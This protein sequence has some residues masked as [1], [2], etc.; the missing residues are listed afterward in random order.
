MNIESVQTASAL[1]RSSPADAVQQASRQAKAVA[2]QVTS[3][4][5]VTQA[6]KN[7]PESEE[8]KY[9]VQEAVK[10][11]EAFVSLTSADI[12]FSIDEASGIQVVKILDRQS[13][14]V[15]RQFPSE[16]AIR[17]AQALDQL[18]GVFVKE[19]V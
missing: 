19:K 6:Q 8:L 1:Q 13:K 14:E 12:N 17:I 2:P 10:Q 16:E 4:A 5:R 15:I 11:L 3:P 9:S 7:K 18:Q